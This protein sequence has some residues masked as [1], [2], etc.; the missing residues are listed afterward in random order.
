[1]EIKGFG[2]KNG[3]II[4]TETKKSSPQIDAIIYSGTP[5]LEFRDVAFVEKEQVKA[6]FE[7]KSWIFQTDLFGSSLATAYKKRKDFLPQGVEYILFAFELHSKSDDADVIKRLSNN[8]ICDSY[9]AVIR[10]PPR[11][12]NYDGSVGRLIEWLRNLN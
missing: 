10:R 5:L 7:I 8:E 12:I 3:L 9:A 1:M 4:D 2:L 6:I 11:V